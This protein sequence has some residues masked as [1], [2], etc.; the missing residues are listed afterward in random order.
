MA[1]AGEVTFDLMGAGGAVIAIPVYVNGKGPF[2][3]LLD[4]GATLT[5]V[6][7]ELADRL[8]LPERSGQGMVGIVPLGGGPPRFVGI[9]S[10]RVGAARASGLT[11]CALDLGHVRRMGL[12]LDGLVG[13]NFL[14]AFRVT[15]D[16]KRKIL[17]LEEA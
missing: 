6:D 3:F 9:D 11:A 12:A 16:F 7:R 14:K 1:A 10:L 5:C 13:L 15:I 2:R 8:G 17:R 4:T